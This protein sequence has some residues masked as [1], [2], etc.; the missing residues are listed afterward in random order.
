MN[1]KL[2]LEKIYDPSTHVF[3]WIGHRFQFNKSRM[4]QIWGTTKVY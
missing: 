4:V 2:D 3:S 1:Q